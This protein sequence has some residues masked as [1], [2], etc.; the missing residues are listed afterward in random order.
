MSASTIFG[1][2]LLTFPFCGSSEALEFNIQKTAPAP[3]EGN[4]DRKHYFT[5]AR[6]TVEK[7]DLTKFRAFLKLAGIRLNT[8]C[9]DGGCDGEAVSVVLDSPGGNLNEALKIAEFFAQYQPLNTAV[10]RRG[11]I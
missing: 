4:R 6:G 9:E 7:G 2:L 1:A 11:N 10:E 8:Q 5:E 3:D